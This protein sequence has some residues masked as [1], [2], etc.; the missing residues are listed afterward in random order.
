MN[1]LT[2]QQGD[3]SRGL[4]L[5]DHPWRAMGEAAPRGSVGPTG[6]WPMRG[7][8]NLFSMEIMQ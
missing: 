2:V 6:V 3:K 4:A 7:R 8:H 1:A 5:V